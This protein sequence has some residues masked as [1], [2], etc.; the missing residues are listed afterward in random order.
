MV[1]DSS[2]IGIGFL[3][4]YGRRTRIGGD[5]IQFERLTSLS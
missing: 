3:L 4:P 5:Q 1:R 2:E